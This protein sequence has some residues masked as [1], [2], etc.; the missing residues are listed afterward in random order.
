MIKG[1]QDTLY[2]KSQQVIVRCSAPT[3]PPQQCAA[4]EWELEA[5]HKPALYCVLNRTKGETHL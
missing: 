2:E 3:S 1:K 4:P 5:F